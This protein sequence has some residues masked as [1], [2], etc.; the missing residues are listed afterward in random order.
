MATLP[1]RASCHVSSDGTI[2]MW[3]RYHP[4]FIEVLKSSIPS[5]YR[6][7]NPYI[8]N[9]SWTIM[10]AYAEV[11]AKLLIEYFPDAVCGGQGSRS[12]PSAT[13]IE[14]HTDP[15]AVLHVRPGAPLEVIDAA[16][17]ALAKQ[18]H[19]DKG[20]DQATM[21]RLIEA[22]AALRQRVSA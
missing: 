22:H 3:F 12:N 7:Y 11:A 6:R 20:G 8:G 18:H 9:K 13:T 14:S 15:S 10:P 2:T 16:F 5:A 1:R 19:P 4:A 21:R 17:R